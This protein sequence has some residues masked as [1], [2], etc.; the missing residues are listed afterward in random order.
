MATIVKYLIYKSNTFLYHLS[1]SNDQLYPKRIL[2]TFMNNVPSVWCLFSSVKLYV[3]FYM[4][5][6]IVHLKLI[7]YDLYM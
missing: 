1:I 4:N 3:K 7:M 5:K 2:G 6:I